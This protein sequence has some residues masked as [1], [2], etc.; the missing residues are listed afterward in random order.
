M[1]LY[2]TTTQKQAMAKNTKQDT[3]RHI[4]HA[5]IYIYTH[6]QTSLLPR[7]PTGPRVLLCRGVQLLC[8]FTMMCLVLCL[9]EFLVLLLGSSLCCFIHV[10]YTMVPTFV[11]FCV[12]FNCFLLLCCVLHFCFCVLRCRGW[13][14][15]K[16]PRIP[17]TRFEEVPQDPV[18]L[19]MAHPRA[20]PEV[21]KIF[22]DLVVGALLPED[23]AQCMFCVFVFCV[24]FACKVHVLC[25]C[26][27]VFVIVLICVC[28][29][30]DC[31]FCCCC[32][33]CC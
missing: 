25:V 3:Q 1:L 23:R 8:C 4:M 27:C 9:L 19:R 28:C 5:C 11:L 15:A 21:H 24:L 33:C 26:V 10:V 16:S 22:E 30:R 13:S 20:P 12:L 18:S 31:V 17:G 6:L 14:L 29:L 7:V 32:G 2:P